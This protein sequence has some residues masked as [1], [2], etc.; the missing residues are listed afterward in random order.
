MTAEQGS[1]ADARPPKGDHEGPSSHTGRGAL[2]VGAALFDAGRHHAAH[3]VFEEAWIAARG[4]GRS[5]EALWWQGLV[6]CAGALHHRGTGNRSGQK[7][8]GVRAIERL[9]AALDGA[10]N[11][12]GTE[13]APWWTHRCRTW[14]ERWRAFVAAEPAGADPR[15]GDLVGEAGADEA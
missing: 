9:S 7:A 11:S 12:G 15:L 5:A 3:E 8:L 13:G 2:S 1:S 6:L 10:A 14:L 4:T